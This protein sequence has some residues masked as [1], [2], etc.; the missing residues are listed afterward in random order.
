MVQK[1][2]KPFIHYDPEADVLALYWQK[3]SEEEF[4]EFAPNVS[5]E[6]DKKGRMIGLEILNASRFL[7]PAMKPLVERMRARIH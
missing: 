6:L 4:V 2:K 5:V 1:N 3:G 7:R